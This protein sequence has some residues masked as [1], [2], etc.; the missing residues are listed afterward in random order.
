MAVD[1]SGT[2]LWLIAATD[3]RRLVLKSA[4]PP[5][6]GKNMVRLDGGQ[7]VMGDEEHYP[8]ERPAHQVSVGPLLVDARP[9]TNADF[10]RFVRATDYQTV[11]EQVPSAADF[12]DADPADLVPGSLVFQR[13]A[14][15]VALDDWRRWWRW[16][17]GASWRAPNGP[18]SS[19]GG[20]ELHPVV[21]VA[22]ADTQAYAQ[23]A[24]KELPTEAEWEF[25]ARGG[26]ANQQYSWGD[27]FMPRGKVMANTWHGRFPWENLS[28]HG[29]TGTSP[30]GRFPPNGYGLLDMI[31]NVW[32]W[33]GSAWTPDH[34]TA[35]PAAQS[36]CCCA[37]SVAPVVS[38]DDDR[39]V[40][41][42][43][44]HLCAPSY[45]QRYRPAARQ[46]QQAQSSTGHLGFRCV[47]RE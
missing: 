2:T 19:I 16:Q 22:F 7:F 11:A 45:C 18:G 39:R 30:V 15:P 33:T 36:H 23:W 34:S 9:V 46:G 47:V 1:R 38:I 35:A 8:E 14:G 43:G 12:P 21:H 3:R 20:R 42:G 10:A 25:A 37:P 32:E 40:M 41:K 27:E 29:Y 4:T 13:A 28:P 26:G 24:G 31:G 5:A 44:S 17:P 6:V